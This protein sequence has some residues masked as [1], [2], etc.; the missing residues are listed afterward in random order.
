MKQKLLLNWIWDW[1]W[2]RVRVWFRVRWSSLIVTL[3][4]FFM[5]SILLYTSFIVYHDRICFK[6][7]MYFGPLGFEHVMRNF[8]NPLSILYFGEQI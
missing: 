1:I 8:F 3:I 2:L 6:R 5:I 4:G 7:N